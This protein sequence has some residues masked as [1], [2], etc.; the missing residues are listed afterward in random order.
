MYIQNSTFSLDLLKS[1]SICLFKWQLK[2][3]TEMLPTFLHNILHF[4]H[5]QICNIHKYVPPQYRL[6]FQFNF[7]IAGPQNLPA[8]LLP[9]G[10]RKCDMK[11]Q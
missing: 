11:A 6:N 9:P 8:Y 3:Y 4:I 1:L 7:L 2:W 10:T 5:F